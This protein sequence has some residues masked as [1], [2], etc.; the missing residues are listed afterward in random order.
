[1]QME[2][3]RAPKQMAMPTPVAQPV[4]APKGDRPTAAQ[5]V[6]GVMRLKNGGA[7][8]SSRGNGIAVRGKTK[9]KMY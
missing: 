7:V 1:M 8:S 4:S 9:C 5:R 6:A 3:G 2:I